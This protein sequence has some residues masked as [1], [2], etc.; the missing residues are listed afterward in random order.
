MRGWQEP[1]G[2][3]TSRCG[4]QFQ[5]AHRPPE[6]RRLA[7]VVEFCVQVYLRKHVLRRVGRRHRAGERAVKY[8]SALTN[9]ASLIDHSKCRHPV[10]GV[11]VAEALSAARV[12]K[13]WSSPSGEF[14]M[15]EFVGASCPG[16]CSG[17]R[18]AIA[19]DGDAIADP[20]AVGALE[21]QICDD[22]DV[23]AHRGRNLQIHRPVQH[24]FAR[25]RTARVHFPIEK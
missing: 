1:A 13:R 17:G 8:S 7:P 10:H 24:Q 22:V 23:G 25:S 20:Y 6:C 3:L 21:Q 11:P 19:K 4:P 9:W 12:T 15:Y 14:S 18:A 2:S 16:R 5:L